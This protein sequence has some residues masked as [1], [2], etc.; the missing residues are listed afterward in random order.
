[1][2]ENHDLKVSR[3]TLRKWMP[4]R[5]LLSASTRA[6]LFDI[7]TDFEDLV[8]HYLLSPSDLELIRTR[9]RDENRFGLAVHVSLLRHPSKLC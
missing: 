4:P 2:A 6:D 7:L 3:E 1:L 5:S 8:H 9:R